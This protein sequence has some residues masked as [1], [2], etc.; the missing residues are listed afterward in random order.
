M[1]FRFYGVTFLS[2]MHTKKRVNFEIGLHVLGNGNVI[3]VFKSQPYGSIGGLSLS[4][5]N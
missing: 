2:C 5:S 1:S 3:Y 4:C